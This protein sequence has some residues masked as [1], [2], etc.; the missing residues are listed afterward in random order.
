MPHVEYLGPNNTDLEACGRDRG[1][2][3][4]GSCIDV[5]GEVPN[6]W[7]IKQNL[8]YNWVVVKELNLNCHIMDT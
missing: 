1:E 6:G 2:T 5:G 3:R 7:Y 4:L 8:A